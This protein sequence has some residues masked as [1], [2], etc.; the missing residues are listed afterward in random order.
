VTF[1]I[2]GYNEHLANW[3][4]RVK[5][6]LI[7]DKPIATDMP[8]KV[9]GQ[10][11]SHFKVVVQNASTKTIVAAKL[12]VSFPE[13]RGAEKVVHGNR[14]SV[15]GP[16]VGSLAVM[17]S[18]LERE[19]YLSRPNLEGRIGFNLL[20]R[21][22]M[23]FGLPSEISIAPGEL[24]TFT[25]S[26]GDRD[27]PCIEKLASGSITKA[28][29]Y[30]QPVVFNGDIQHRIEQRVWV[31]ET[32]YELPETGISGGSWQVTTPEQFLPKPPMPQ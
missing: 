17:E 27:M 11:P 24:T 6:I 5:Q 3:P 15:I 8:V 12:I 13:T 18:D 29:I 2:P 10:W 32:F 19:P 9:D 28:N 16:P 21:N 14:D 1:T 26:N 25:I 23:G 22:G 31:D 20:L 30:I 4:I 7:G